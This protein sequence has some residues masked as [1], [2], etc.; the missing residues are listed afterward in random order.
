VITDPVIVRAAPV[1]E[2]PEAEVGRRAVYP[3][4]E[5][6]VRVTPERV[7]GSAGNT[8]VGSVERIC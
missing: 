4:L 7:E 2:A 3:E 8:W 1:E 5:R 6:V